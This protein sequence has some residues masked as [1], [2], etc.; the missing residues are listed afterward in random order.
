MSCEFNIPNIPSVCTS[1][2]KLAT[3]ARIE[4]DR[5]KLKNLYSRRPASNY[6]DRATNILESKTLNGPLALNLWLKYS[7]ARGVQMNKKSKSRAR[8][9]SS[10]SLIDKVA[11]RC[12]AIERASN[13]SFIFD[14]EL[15]VYFIN[16]SKDNIPNPVQ[17]EFVTF[18]SRPDTRKKIPRYV[19]II[20]DIMF[21]T[22]TDVTRKK[23]ATKCLDACSAAKLSASP[24]VFLSFRVFYRDMVYRTA[25]E[26]VRTIASAPLEDTVYEGGG[27][28][29]A[30]F[31]WTLY[32]G[33]EYGLVDFRKCVK[34]R[35]V[36]P[37][38]QET[39]YFKSI[40]KKKKRL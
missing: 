18:M 33:R 14:V 5:K 12:D 16:T 28:Q 20:D 11:S 17:S 37:T 29:D 26:V 4:E 32:N 6:F 22:D 7:K 31:V 34:A 1:K 8:A 21:E 3:I 10:S 19:R 38:A 35:P 39:S 13:L 24:S 2:N 9:S 40:G 25:D 23:M 36:R 27:N 30:N 15:C